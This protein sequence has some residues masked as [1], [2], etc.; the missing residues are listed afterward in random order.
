[1]KKLNKT[2]LIGVIAVF[3]AACTSHNDGNENESE[4]NEDSETIIVKH[5][6]GETGVDNSPEKAIVFDFGSLD[7]L[8]ELDIDVTGVPAKNVPDYLDKYEGKAYENSGA[9][10]ELDFEKIAEIDP[11]LIIISGRE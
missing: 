7:T 9:L 5:Q 2:L 8:D 3:L 11:D 4:Q 10:K 1:M 6:L